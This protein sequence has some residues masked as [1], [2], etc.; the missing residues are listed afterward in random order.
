M[1]ADKPEG[2]RSDRCCGIAPHDWLDIFLEDALETARAG[3]TKSA[4][5]CIKRSHSMSHF[6][7]DP[8][9]LLLIHVAWF[10]KS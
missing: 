2:Q 8:E 9:A 7:N 4:Y 1:K 3:D 10:S 6:S 5:E